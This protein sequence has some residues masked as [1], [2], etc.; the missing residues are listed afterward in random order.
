M[1]RILLPLLLLSFTAKADLTKAPKNFKFKSGKQAVYVDF[2]TVDSSI[3]YDLDREIATVETIITFES[4][5]EGFPI[6]DLV[7]NVD[8]ASLN[9]KSVK[10]LRIPSPNNETD[11]KLVDKNILPGTHTLTITNRILSNISFENTYVSSGFWMS[12]LSDRTYIEKYLPANIEFDQYQLNL[13]V[14]IH[15]TQKFDAHEIFTNGVINGDGKNFQIAFP[16]YFT[17]SSFYFHLTKKNRLPSEKFQFT[18]ISGKII[19]I[20]LYARSNWSMSGV[21]NEILSILKELEGKFGEWSHPSL[22][23]Y[24]A[25][26]GGMEYS[27]ATITSHRALGHEL[28]HSYFARGVM[29]IDGNSGWM[30]EAIASWRDDGYKTRSKPNFRST[31]MSAH[32]QYRRYT[33]RKAYNQGARFMEY[34]NAELSKMG[35]LANFLKSLHEVYTHTSINTHTFKK[36]LEEFSGKDYTS[37]FNKYIFGKEEFDEKHI[38][39]ENPYHPKLTKKQLMDLL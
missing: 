32:S 29:P 38:N 7:P 30:D 26:Q 10:V 23:V 34:L 12:D 25:G 28:T 18:T 1:K 27:G 13:N 17:A 33:D 11:Y 19:P 39:H 9:G 14:K 24:I 8:S 15:S 4:A 2:Q 36:E 3:I 37:D 31:S 5:V 6:F 35:G 20:S 22:T 21:K 16:A